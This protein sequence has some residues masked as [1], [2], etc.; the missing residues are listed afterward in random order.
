MSREP[1]APMTKTTAMITHLTATPAR[2][3]A[4]AFRG[5]FWVSKHP[6]TRSGQHQQIADRNLP[7]VADRRL[8]SHGAPNPKLK[9]RWA[10][11][12]RDLDDAL[13]KTGKTNAAKPVRSRPAQANNHFSE[14]EPLIHLAP[15]DMSVSSLAASAASDPLAPYGHTSPKGIISRL[16]RAIL[17]RM[18]RILL[19]E[20]GDQGGWGML[21][22]KTGITRAFNAGFQSRQYPS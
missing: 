18:E 4:Q 8:R 17:S 15:A 19:C 14:T 22:S 16:C 2:V 5:Q 6:H 7:P 3:I 10:Y 1:S 12:P 21:L 9:K 13:P 11:I 20:Q